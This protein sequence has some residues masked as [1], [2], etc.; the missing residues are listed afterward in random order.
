MTRRKTGPA[1]R[2]EREAP[3]KRWPVALL[4]TAGVLVAGYLG[5][6]QLRGGGALF[7]TAGSGCDVVQ[8]S[9]YAVLLGLPIALWG[10]GLYA[11][12]GGLALWGLS[13]RRWL[14]VFLLAVAG[15][16]FSLY[17]TYLELFVIKAVCA[18]C[19]VSAGIALALFGAL[20]W[21]RPTPV[22]RRSPVR[23]PRIATLGAVTAVVTVVV[24]AA[25]FAMEPAR[26]AS[27]YQDALARHLAASGAVMYGAYW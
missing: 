8:A 15:A 21:Q 20:L 11:L 23:T 25:I 16:S 22:G 10:A 2:E 7:C 1:R 9:R 6:T 12:I 3:P 4:S 26:E 18:Y 19:L 24:G 5:I 14:A 17:L 13:A 27:A